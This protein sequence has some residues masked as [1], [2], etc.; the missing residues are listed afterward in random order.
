MDC[1]FYSPLLYFSKK[2]MTSLTYRTTD[3]CFRFLRRRD[4]VALIPFLFTMTPQKIV[5]SFISLSTL[6]LDIHALTPFVV[7]TSNR[8]CRSDSRLFSSDWASFSALDDDE[9]F[10]TP[11]D[12]REYAVEDD[13]QEA[14]AEVGAALEPP[15]IDFDAEP[16]FVP[17]GSQL[18]L[19]EP[20]VLGVLSA[21]RAEIGTMFGYTAENRGVGI[22]GGKLRDIHR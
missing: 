20:T 17:I 8:P 10:D 18:E 21:C 12:K 13:S 3:G 9:D 4:D 11:I 5:L 16:I 6:A 15:S 19:D 22:T 14:K 2:A 1:S 7:S